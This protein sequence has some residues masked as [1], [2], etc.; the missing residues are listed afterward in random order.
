[1]LLITRF[2]RHLQ[3]VIVAFRCIV[4]YNVHDICGYAD[5]GIGIDTLKERLRSATTLYDEQQ[6]ATVGGHMIQDFGLKTAHGASE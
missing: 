5:I 6:S 1:M 4:F 3:A 2:L